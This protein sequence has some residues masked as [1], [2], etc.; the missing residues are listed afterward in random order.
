MAG[1]VAPVPDARATDSGAEAKGEGAGQESGP[2]RTDAEGIARFREQAD[3]AFAS[4]AV[5]EKKRW[6]RAWVE[7]AEGFL[8]RRLRAAAPSEKRKAG[9]AP[10]AARPT[11]PCS[12]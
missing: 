9:L 5:R 7:G 11:P 6:V 3:A 10:L 4:G 1:A 2:P 12:I 8:A